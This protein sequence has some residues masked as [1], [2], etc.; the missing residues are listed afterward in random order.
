MAVNLEPIAL[1]DGEIVSKVVLHESS[2]DRSRPRGRR[3]SARRVTK[4]VTVCFT[5]QDESGRVEHVECPLVDLSSSGIGLV[6]DK[7]I[8]VDRA[9][10]V[11]FQTASH[12]LVRVHARVKR[13][14]CIGESRYEVGLRFTHR[15]TAEQQ[16][17]VKRRPGRDITIGSR[18]RPLASTT[19]VV[20]RG[21]GGGYAGPSLPM[22]F[23]D[24][25]QNLELKVDDLTPRAIDP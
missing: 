1:V 10:Q 17:I 21:M 6:Y 14:I 15:I 7:P 25:E 8:D 20:P 4:G 2:L 3:D 13:C 12:R 11:A 9:C 23:A 24:D 22:S 19:P 16:L 18:M 5:P